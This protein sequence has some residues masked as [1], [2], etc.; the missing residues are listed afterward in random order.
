MLGAFPIRESGGGVVYDPVTRL[1]IPIERGGQSW[2]FPSPHL[3]LVGSA[4]A[5]LDNDSTKPELTD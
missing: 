4:P 2:S 5:L 1:T 3:N